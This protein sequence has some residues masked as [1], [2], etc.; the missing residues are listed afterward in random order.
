MHLNQPINGMARTRS[1]HGYWL[2]AS[3]GGIFSF[4]DAKF[5]GSTGAIHLNQPIVGMA[6]TPSG[7]GYWLVASDGGMF[8]FGDAKFYGSTGAMHL[9]QPIVGMAPTPTRARLLARS[10]V[11]AACS[12]SATRSSTA[13][14]ARCT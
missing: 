12:R 9:N 5:H 11:T 7:R 4:G 8:T 2:V 14:P 1:G 10:R 3:D 13:R 6:A